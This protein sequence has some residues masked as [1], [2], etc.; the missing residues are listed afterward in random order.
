SGDASNAAADDQGGI[1]E[2]TVVSPA[3]PTL[4]TNPSPS[5]VTLGTSA[6]TL[7]HSATLANR[8]HPARTIT[9]TLVA[10]GGGTGDTATATG[11]GTYT[12]GNGI[13]LPTRG[14]VTG[15]NQWNSTYTG[16][17]NNNPATDIGAAN[18]HVTVTPASP[19]LVT[20]ASPDVT[21]PAAPPGTVTLTDTA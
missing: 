12:P 15:T 4:T 21:L 7:T 14:A 6:V 2:Q 3:S 5:T 1:A 19:A 17:P 9:S 13:P 8:Y 16:G 11:T 20:T 18:E 10:Q